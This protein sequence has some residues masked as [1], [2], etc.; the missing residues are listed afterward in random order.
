[1]SITVTSIQGTNTLCGFLEIVSVQGSLGA[2]Q[3]GTYKIV[4]DAKGK[5]VRLHAGPVKKLTGAEETF[6]LYFFPGANKP[7]LSLHR[8]PTEPTAYE[9]S[10]VVNKLT[11]ETYTTLDKFAGVNRSA[12]G[13]QHSGEIISHGLCEARFASAIAAGDLVTPTPTGFIA[14]TATVD[15][16]GRCITGAGA[17]EYG[18]IYLWGITGWGAFM[19][20]NVRQIQVSNSPVSWDS[21]WH[22]NDRR[23]YGG[24]PTAGTLIYPHAYFYDCTTGV[25]AYDYVL[26]NGLGDLFPIG[27]LAPGNSSFGVLSLMPAPLPGWPAAGVGRMEIRMGVDDGREVTTGAL[28]G[29]NTLTCVAAVRPLVTHVITNE[30][31]GATLIPN[32]TNPA[33]RF[34]ITANTMVNMPAGG[35]F[36]VTVGATDDLT[37]KV[38]ANALIIPRGSIDDLSCLAAASYMVGG[39]SY[40]S[41]MPFGGTI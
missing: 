30:F 21:Q 7:G 11:V 10:V 28:V 19:G 32:A 1:M 17:G 34:T 24:G 6:T 38:G 31:V 13:A 22:I 9:D 27:G 8:L 25:L 12:V 26:G 37:G 35:P 29:L 4:T 39:N 16:V 40:F 41:F 36:T 23:F 5:S 33:V 14:T 3:S 2:L 15:A 20:K 18:A